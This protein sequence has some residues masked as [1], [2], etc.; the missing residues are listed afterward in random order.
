MK[1]SEKIQEF[2]LSAYFISKRNNSF[3]SETQKNRAA[4]SRSFPA[5]V[6]HTISAGYP[7]ST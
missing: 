3:T 1:Q 7:F 2:S 5:D 6:N 4:D